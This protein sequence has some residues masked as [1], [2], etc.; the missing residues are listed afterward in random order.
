MCSCLCVCVCVGGGGQHPLL[1]KGV[2]VK[3]G[4]PWEDSEDDL[5]DERVLACPVSKHRHTDLW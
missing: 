2:T 3:G 1:A 4:K 5:L